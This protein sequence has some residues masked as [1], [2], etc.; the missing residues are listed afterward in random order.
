MKVKVLVTL[1]LK[2]ANLNCSYK[3][4]KK[5]SN[6]SVVLSLHVIIE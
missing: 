5:L 2:V 3:L 1:N 4:N 6:C